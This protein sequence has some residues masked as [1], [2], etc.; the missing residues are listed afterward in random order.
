MHRWQQL[1]LI[2]QT[3]A[4]FYMVGFIWFTQL[5]HYPLL[6]KLTKYRAG[7]YEQSNIRLTTWVVGPV[8]VV[9]IV[10]AYLLTLY[11]VPHMPRWIPWTG[12]A[13][14]ILIWLSTGS[15]LAPKHQIL[16]K[17]YVEATHM[18]L[19][20]LNWIRTLLWTFRGV[21]LCYALMQ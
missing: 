4:T 3:A 14:L 17:Q 16:A 11:P 18:S 21:L 15:L 13:A 2:I 5:V 8:M 9:E 7:A 19:I 20:K 1:A 12:L 10:T 6:D